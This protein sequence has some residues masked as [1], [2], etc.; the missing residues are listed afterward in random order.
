MG[1]ESKIHTHETQLQKWEEH[2]GETVGSRCDSG[3][4]TREPRSW[5]TASRFAVGKEE[6]LVLEHWNSVLQDF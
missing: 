5:V 3:R 6:S 1:S 2:I 4:K